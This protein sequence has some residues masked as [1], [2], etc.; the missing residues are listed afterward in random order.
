MQQRFGIPF[1]F[2]GSTEVAA[3]LCESILMR[4]WK[5]HAKALDEC[6]KATKRMKTAQDAA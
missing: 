5:E 4:W 3:H 2:A 6:R 1:L